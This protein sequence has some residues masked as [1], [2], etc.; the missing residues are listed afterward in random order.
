MPKL[1]MLVMLLP[2]LVACGGKDGA[3]DSAGHDSDTDGVGGSDSDADGGCYQG[4]L[5]RCNNHDD[6]CDGN[7]DEDAVDRWAWYS[8]S[9]GDG[10]GNPGAYVVGCDKP[11]ATWVSNDADCDDGQPTV[12]PG[13]DELC[14]NLRDDDCDGLVDSDDDS[15][16]D[17]EPWWVDDDVD[18]W[19]GGAP[20]W[21]CGEVDQMVGR[22]G[23][24]DDSDR[25]VYPFAAELADQLDNDCDGGVDEGAGA[26]EGDP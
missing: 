3:P 5:E 26:G 22:G 24:C 15:V 19:G 17:L 21:R 12:H 4:A 9:D 6:D 20:E 8:D 10:Y 23:D 18:G 14:G 25:S 11:G 13:A 7:V 1:L 2:L 16:T